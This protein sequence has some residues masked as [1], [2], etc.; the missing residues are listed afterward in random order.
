MPLAMSVRRRDLPFNRGRYWSRRWDSYKGSP[1][2]E[3]PDSQLGPADVTQWATSLK[4]TQVTESES[5]P[6]WRSRNKENLSDIGGPFKTQLKTVQS[7]PTPYSYAVEYQPVDVDGKPSLW[8]YR[9]RF[10]GDVLPINPSDARVVFP[11]S[12]ES[13]NTILEALGTKAI[14]IVKPT[15]SVANISTTLL[16]MYKDGIPKLIGHQLWKKRTRRVMTSQEALKDV[17]GD[18]LSY[19]F[20]WK[21]LINDIADFSKAVMDMD[22]ILAQYE[23]DAGRVVRRTFEFPTEESATSATILTNTRPFIGSGGSSFPAALLPAQTGKVT[24][25]NT[26]YRK[27]WFSGAF[28]YRLPSDFQSRKKL[29]RYASRAEK[30]FGVDLTPEVLWAI[31]PWSWAV[32]WIVNVGDVISNATDWSK[33][34]LVLRYGY[35]M[36]HS[37]SVRTFSYEGPAYWP[38]APLPA[39][40]VLVVETKKRV[41]AT[42]FG[43]GLTWEGFS[44]RQLAILASLG[45]TRKK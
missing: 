27:R 12:L 36:E 35:M 13:S 18:H 38:G 24:M 21:P 9:Y 44:P 11:P 26:T 15:S 32:D 30:L 25:V 41:Q 2:G 33:D 6:G 4:G 43:F 34:G 10:D 1:F 17:A 19:E 16:E 37:R 39:P 3:Q 20:A 42:P 5:H 45:I 23:R 29:A 40:L 28:T 31:A 22:K 14:A 7:V 8:K